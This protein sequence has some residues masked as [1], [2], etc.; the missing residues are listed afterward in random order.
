MDHLRRNDEPQPT[1]AVAPPAAS[2]ADEEGRGLDSAEPQAL[3]GYLTIELDVSDLPAYI[4]DAGTPANPMERGAND[5]QEPGGEPVD[6]TDS[7]PEHMRLD[8]LPGVESEASEGSGYL[9]IEL[10]DPEAMA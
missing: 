4:R 2:R 5:L 1:P 10:E 7:V 8:A 9:T 3:A 6:W